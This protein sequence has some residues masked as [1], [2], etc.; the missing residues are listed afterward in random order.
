MRNIVAW[1]M[2]L[3]FIALGICDILGKR[4]MIGVASLMLGAC[5]YIFLIYKVNNV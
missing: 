5:Q 3:S 1:I 2:V 4:Y